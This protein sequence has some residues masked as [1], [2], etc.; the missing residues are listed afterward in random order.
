MS[1]KIILLVEDNEDDEVLTLRALNRS[2]LLAHVDVVRDGVEA[3][4]YLMCEGKYADRDCSSQPHLILLDFK[5]PK[6]DGADVVKA[7]RENIQTRHIPIVML[8]TS[9]EENDL[10]RCYDNG[11]NSYV[12]KPL[13]FNEFMQIV[14][15]LG[16]YW[17]TINNVPQD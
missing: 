17:L 2:D 16:V 11:A 12:K 1:Q 6:L 5:L 7:I 9:I 10:L 8:S 14:T 4:E 15:L 3:L 13:D